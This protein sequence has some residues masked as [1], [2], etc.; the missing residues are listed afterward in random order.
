MS[1][2]A[3]PNYVFVGGVIL[4]DDDGTPDDTSR[5][6][7][8]EHGDSADHWFLLA[9]MPEPIPNPDPYGFGS[10]GAYDFRGSYGSP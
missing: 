7:L 10:Y 1:Y 6:Y 8:F 2:S 5:Y 9:P 3:G 4:L